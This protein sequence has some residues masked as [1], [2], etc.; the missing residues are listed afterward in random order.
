MKRTAADGV[1]IWFWARNDGSVPADVKSGAQ[2]LTPGDSWGT[3]DASF[4]TTS[5]D[6]ASH[7][8]DH[9]IIFDLTFCVSLKL[10]SN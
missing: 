9:R 3:P 10:L 4:P 5:C 6:W 1:D 8:S 7:F 2:S